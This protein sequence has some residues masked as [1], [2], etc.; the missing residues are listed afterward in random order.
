LLLKPHYILFY[1]SIGGEILLN[2]MQIWKLHC[3][4]YGQYVSV[5]RDI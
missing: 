3:I 2:L 1:S 4:P 5:P